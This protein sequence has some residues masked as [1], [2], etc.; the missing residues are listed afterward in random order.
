MLAP[1]LAAQLRLAIANTFRA[2]AM[3]T[4][5]ASRRDLR[6]E[7]CSQRLHEILSVITNKVL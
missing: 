3:Q 6:Q 4:L 5:H 7:F 1:C 2:L